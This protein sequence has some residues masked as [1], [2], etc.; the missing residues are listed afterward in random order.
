MLKV[1]ERTPVTIVTMIVV[2]SHAMWSRFRHLFFS[3]FFSL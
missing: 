1:K 3:F 2:L